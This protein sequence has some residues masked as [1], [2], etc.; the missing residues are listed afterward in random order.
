MYYLSDNLKEE[1][2]KDLSRFDN[3]KVLSIWMMDRFGSKKE[4]H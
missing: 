4:D 1:T 3:L 2:W